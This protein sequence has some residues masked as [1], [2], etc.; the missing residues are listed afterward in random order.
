MSPERLILVS[1]SP[2]RRELL[3]KF[4]YDFEV[5]DPVESEGRVRFPEDTIQVAKGKIPPVDAP[6]IYLSADTMVFL[7]GEPLGKPRTREEAIRFLQRL[8]GQ[9]HRVVTGFYLL[10]VPGGEAQQGMEVT[11]VRFA[12]LSRTEI[13]WLVEHDRPW[14]KA[15]A[16]G[17]QGLAGLLI[18]WIRGSYFNVVGLPIERIYPLLK[19]WGIVPRSFP[20]S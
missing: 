11:E 12:A 15:G 20:R 1:R 14:D 4:E 16:Y 10:R 17:I 18:P 7:D 2:R 9:I 8:S 5:L 19:R 13:E 6:G 3:A